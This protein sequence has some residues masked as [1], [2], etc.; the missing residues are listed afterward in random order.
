M[1]K[2]YLIYL[3]FFMALS[4][5]CDKDDED[6]S[7]AANYA[8]ISGEQGNDLQME[9]PDG[10]IEPIGTDFFS[11]WN[12][13]QLL[14]GNYFRQL[15]I[16]TEYGTMDF[17]ISVPKDTA[18]QDVVERTHGLEPRLLLQNT[19]NLSRVVA[20]L[21][22]GGSTLFDEHATG[23]VR[24]E[25]SVDLEDQNYAIVGEVDAIFYDQQNQAHKVTGHFWSKEV[26]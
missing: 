12:K 26:D 23:T 4:V 11:G 9:L 3:S 5:S 10:T 2:I 21:W 13:G 22:I 8:F 24:I 6:N 16:G 15:R 19:Q 20:E 17:R 14:N 7:N 18:F 1:K 25:E